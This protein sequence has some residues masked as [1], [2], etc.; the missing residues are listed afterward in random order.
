M[1][2]LSKCF[3]EHGLLRLPFSLWVVPALVVLSAPVLWAD[4]GF[5]LR[6]GNFKW[7]AGFWL[8]PNRQDWTDSEGLKVLAEPDAHRDPSVKVPIQM[9]GGLW[10]AQQVRL[11]PGEYELSVEVQVDPEDDGRVRL[12]GGSE[13]YTKIQGPTDQPKERWQRMAVRFE[14]SAT[15]PTEVKIEGVRGSF[16][17]RAPRIDIVQLKTAAV[18]CHQGAGIG[19]IVLPENPDPAEAYAA[20]ELQFFLW[21]MTG[22]APGIAGRDAV[23]DGRVMAIG[24]AATSDRRAALQGLSPEAYVV[25]VEDQRITLAGNS[26]RATLYAAY[27]FLKTQGCRWYLPGKR[28]EVIPRQNAI[29]LAA[30]VRHESPDWNVRGFLLHPTNY[31]PR[32]QVVNVLGN[33]YFDWAARNRINAVWHGSA[34]THDLGAHRGGSHIQRLNHAWFSFL[35][36]DPPQE[37]AALVNGQRQFWHA[38]GR[39][40]MVCTTNPDYRDRVVSQIVK[41]FHEHPHARVAACSADDEPV[42]WCQCETC[43]ALDRDGGKGP[44]ELQDSG[45]PKLPMTDRALHFVNEVAARVS[46]VHPDKQIEMYAYASTGPPPETQRVHPNVLVKITSFQLSPVRSLF[47]RHP[48]TRGM[49]DSLNQWRAMGAKNLGLY[50]Y[51]GFQQIDCPIFWF[52]LV[53]N[54]LRALHERWGMRHY[55]GETDNTIGPSMMLFNIRAAS[56]WDRKTDYQEVLRD[57]CQH[58]YGEASGEMLQYYHHMHQQMLTWELPAGAPTP[59]V[60]DAVEYS[61]PAMITGRNLLQAARAKVVGNVTLLDRIAIA[62]FGHALFTHYIATRNSGP[63]RGR[64]T[65]QSMQVATA[66][67]ARVVAL[68]GRNGNYVI[69]RTRDAL[70]TWRPRPIVTQTLM[71]LPTQWEFKTDPKKQGIDQKWYL[72]K[73]SGDGWSSIRTDNFWTHQQPWTDYRGVAWYRVKLVVPEP[74]RVAMQEALA[75][76]NLRLFFGAVDGRTR[77]FLDGEPLAEQMLDPAIMWDKPF[78]IDLPPG[79]DPAV[80]HE[81][82]LRVSKDRF[83]AGIWK[84]VVIGV[85]QQPARVEKESLAS[86]VID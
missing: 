3:L 31:G 23:V 45:H 12:V 48:S 62:E 70:Q 8:A 32:G 52:F 43:R 5:P 80:E 71:T 41:Y 84:P 40:N 60:G 44:W 78:A 38:S 11:V 36:K 24:R 85:V 34:A 2:L 37:W 73:S 50:D 16:R 15:G 54:H 53:N 33:D 29:R 9:Y 47:E 6:N 51:G 64:E 10:M 46:K 20:W 83:A 4:D 42:H 77:I 49:I 58:F 86:P 75:E 69:D 55:L 27:D 7:G 63:Y 17:I 61:L 81:L 30:G 18:P 19:R 28:G 25:A 76:G 21:K 1:K 59:F 39:P 79:F 68:W 82:V 65:V 67:H 13:Q 22:R 56:L 66:A 14:T 35:P 26:P 74:S 57:I 72:R